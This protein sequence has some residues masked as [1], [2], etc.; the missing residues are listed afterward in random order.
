M[1]RILFHF[2]NVLN[3]VRKTWHN[4]VC[5]AVSIVLA[6]LFELNVFPECS[7]FCKVIIALIPLFF[8]YPI[9]YYFN[10]KRNN[11]LTLIS[12]YQ[13]VTQLNK[14]RKEAHNFPVENKD[15]NVFIRSMD[16]ICKSV[17]YALANVNEKKKTIGY[18]KYCVIVSLIEGSKDNASINPLYSDNGE[19][20]IKYFDKI[21]DNYRIRLCDNSTYQEIFDTY[22]NPPHEPKII[23][24]PR[25]KK[26]IKDGTC[27]SSF[28][29]IK[30]V[31]VLN[32]PYESSCILPIL[33]F[34]NKREGNEMQGYLVILSEDP[35]IFPETSDEMNEELKQF[36]E[37]ISG[38]LYKVC[39]NNKS[40]EN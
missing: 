15:N 1:K 6:V 18:S 8:S 36:L 23:L 24:T 33:P 9:A 10:R 32:M 25:I 2:S 38:Y 31:G 39:I 5:L 17:Y 27:S 22:S 11:V 26:K 29:T 14:I 30:N 4:T 13:L 28:A 20:A 12:E 34:F 35:D 16:S 21:P 40:S 3:L 7:V 19:M 37:S